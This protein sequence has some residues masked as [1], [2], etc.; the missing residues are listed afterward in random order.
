MLLT[1]FPLSF[2]DI[3]DKSELKA[4]FESNCSQIYFIF[5]ENFITLESNLKLKGEFKVLLE[6]FPTSHSLVAHKWFNN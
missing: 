2:T 6:F 4:F 1:L 3:I 5:Y